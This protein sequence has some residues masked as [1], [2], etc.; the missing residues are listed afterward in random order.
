MKHPTQYTDYLE[1]PEIEIG[2]NEILAFTCLRNEAVRIPY[3]LE[4]Y[5]AKGVTKF[6]VVDNGSTDG[7][8][9][10]LRDCEDVVYFYTEGSYGGSGSSREWTQELAHHYGQGHWCLTVDADEILVYPGWETFTIP[11]LC[12]FLDEE[13]SEGLFCIFLDMY[14]D[15]TV[16]KT[17]YKPG[18]PFQEVCPYFEVDTY[19]LHLGTLAP[20]LA[21]TGGPR[22]RVFWDGNLE[23]RG[24]AMRKVPL[25]KWNENT[26][27]IYSTHA[28]ST[29]RLSAITGV[30]MHFKFLSVFTDAV[31][32]ETERGDRRLDTG[33]NKDYQKYHKTLQQDPTFFGP[34]SRKFKHSSDYVRAGLMRVTDDFERYAGLHKRGLKRYRNKSSLGINEATEIFNAKSDSFTAAAIARLWPY[35]NAQ[36]EVAGQL[37]SKHSRIRPWQRA[38]ELSR[39]IRVLDIHDGHVFFQVGEEAWD[40]AA[41]LRVA[42]HLRRSRDGFDHAIDLSSPTADPTLTRDTESMNANV[43]KAKLPEG[44][45]RK[46]LTSEGVFKFVLSI[47]LDGTKKK[48]EVTLFESNGFGESTDRYSGKCPDLFDGQVAGWV[49]DHYQLSFANEV[50][51]YANGSFLSLHSP[52]RAWTGLD[53]VVAR[54]KPMK[55][56]RVPGLGVPIPVPAAFRRGA[57]KVQERTVPGLGFVIP[58]PG[59]LFETGT[60]TLEV[61]VRFSTYAL[62]NTPITLDAKTKKLGARRK[63]A[64]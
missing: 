36:Q 18:Q 39:L 33:Q 14:S 50:A 23:R 4:Y 29:M 47:A 7:S 48:E 25:V 58:V 2:E 13:G 31:A 6:F 8:G 12:T 62:R 55:M 56:W 51:V 54:T 43:F 19:R 38:Q 40:A 53:T 42:I 28:H 26:R 20:F 41:G 63:L 37:W 22:W 52:S 32:E 21:I 1:K 44:E 57:A 61:K 11:E 5:R 3:F 34:W 60:S 27:Y 9:D 49:F 24:P 45:D 59:K 64:S 15:T 16:S 30:L 10:L 46:T 35:V 17:Y